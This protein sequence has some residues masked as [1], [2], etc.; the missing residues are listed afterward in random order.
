M[1]VVRPGEALDRLAPMQGE[2]SPIVGRAIEQHH[3][4]V[5]TLRDCGVRVHEPELR[6]D[7]GYASFPADCALVLEHGAILLR[8]HK[9]ERRREIAAIE[10]WL[11]E[12]GIPIAGRIDAPGLLDGGDVALAGDVAYVG[13]PRSGQRSNTLGRSQ[14]SS[15]LGISGIRLVELALAPEIRRL[16]DVL[17]FVDEDVAIGA[18][19]FVDLAPLGTNVKVIPIPL[20]EQSGAG[21]LPLA[22][23]RVLAN[24]RFRVALP[25]LRKAK[26][27]V[28]AIDLWEFGKVGAGPSSLVLP[29][30]RG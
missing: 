6:D 18:P 17:T 13:V 7:T 23:R 25:T 22:P 4:L 27:D 28:V 29:L 14:L 11:Q 3:I 9:I 12:Y 21:V 8:P 19:D 1:L 5:G 30:K 10:S 16:T 26:I 15:I 24:L 20:G 2:P